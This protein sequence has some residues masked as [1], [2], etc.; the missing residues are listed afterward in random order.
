[1][2]YF[3]DEY[4]DYLLNTSDKIEFAF[5]II[6][7]SIGIPCNILSIIIFARLI[8]NKNNMGFLYIWQCS[9]DICI[10]LF[11]LLI[12]RSKI[13]L[14]IELK[15][16]NQFACKSYAILRS[17]I[18]QASSWVAVLT[19]FDRFTFVL[20][21]HSNRFRFLKSKRNLTCIILALF[22]ILT[23]M[24]LINYFYYV[25]KRD[26]HCSANIKIK[27]PSDVIFFLFRTYF[28]FT[29]MFIFNIIMI[30][31]IIKSNKN[32]SHQ[33]SLGSRKES[34]F[35]FAVVAFDVSYFLLSF[36]NS[37]FLIFYDINFYSRNFFNNFIFH[38]KYVVVSSVTGNL[39][40]C[41]QTF[42]FFMYFAFNKLF[43]KELLNIM[44]RVFRIPGLIFSPQNTS[45]PS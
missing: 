45:R 23:L 38:A 12:N 25:D 34:Q 3:T 11:Y 2:Y 20:Y 28:P 39:S 29:I 36:P 24:N 13:T 35:T 8:K 16:Q 33:R 14:R 26:H 31:K 37:L 22:A 43:R 9:I 18:L 21:G 42:S 40:L 10:L 4:F 5:N 1:M 30:R 27:I 17:T 44:G 15:E 7:S 32:L 6:S 41:E 19:T